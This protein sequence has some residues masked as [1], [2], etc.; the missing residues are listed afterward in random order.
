MSKI[1][2]GSVLNDRGLHKLAVP[3]ERIKIG[4]VV[5]EEIDL[6]DLGKNHSTCLKGRVHCL[7]I[8]AF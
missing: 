1:L 7:A 4:P 8:F 5:I 3:S 2:A 6:K